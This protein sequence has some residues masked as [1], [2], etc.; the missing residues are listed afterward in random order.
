MAIECPQVERSQ[1][2]PEARFGLDRRRFLRKTGCAMLSSAAAIELADRVRAAPAP[3]RFVVDAHM[4][5]WADDPQRFP[6]R[7][8]YIKDFKAPEH[9]GTVEMLIDDM[10]QHGCTHAVLVQ[11]IFH[12]WDNTYIADCVA[13]YPERLR[14]HG[15][16][17]PTDPHVADR[18]EFWMKDRG[19]HGMR[20]SPIY[21][22]DGRHGGDGWLDAPQTHR[23]WKKAAELGA[24]FNF[25]IAPPQLPRLAQMVETHPDVP[26]ILDHFSQVDLGAD[27]P[28]PDFRL[29]LG[30][31]R[32]PNVWVKV[33]ELSSV[34]ASRTYPFP[35]A[36][37]FVQRVYEAFGP[38]RLLFGTGY[39]GTARAAYRRPTLDDE[40]R[41]IRETIPCFDAEDA[42]KILGANAARLW[43]LKPIT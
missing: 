22:R 21:Y 7:H 23:L 40:I 28:E 29:L 19:L 24:V 43:N 17:D 6:F 37:P 13:R 35:D 3:G 27:D 18:L 15:L 1:N 14:A 42:A 8:P 38:D 39:P 2:V 9:P 16:I 34:A 5:V 31:A 26:V 36:Y 4:H 10:D 32:F 12:G 25:F 33:S 20:F 11:V 30:M 41:L